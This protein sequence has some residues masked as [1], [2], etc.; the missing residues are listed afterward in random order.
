MEKWF[1]AMRDG[2]IVLHVLLDHFFAMPDIFLFVHDTDTSITKSC[3]QCLSSASFCDVQ[4]YHCALFGCSCEKVHRLL[5]V[6]HDCESPTRETQHKSALLCEC[7]ARETRINSALLLGCK[8]K[9]MRHSS[10]LRFVLSMML[11]FSLRIDFESS[12]KSLSHAVQTI[13]SSR[14]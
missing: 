14:S 7:K 4:D 12:I 10:A 9:G 11:E 5:S 3:L 2:R 6:T 8:A 13:S 1:Y